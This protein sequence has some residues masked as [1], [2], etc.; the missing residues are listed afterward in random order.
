MPLKIDLHV[1]TCYS[2]DCATTLEEVVLFSKKKGLD[3]VAVT[4][5]DAI[6]GALR[7][8]EG[9][10][11]DLIVI[12]GIEVSTDRGHILG[13][14]VKTRIP[15]GLSIEETIRRIHEA[16]GIAVV[17]HPSAIL[18]NGVGLDEEIASHDLDAVE[19]IN[20]A[21]FPFFLLSYLNRRF[22]DRVSLPQTAGSDSHLPE[23]VGL[24]YTIV[25]NAGPEMAVEE[26]VQAIK[27]GM[28]V[29]FGMPEPWKLRIRRITEKRKEK[30]GLS[31][32]AGKDRNRR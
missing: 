20:S 14:N 17:A 5:H 4:D 26:V 13:I 2:D 15:A 21:D 18:R 27:E 11:T 16:G 6:E 9:E 1:H 8:L 29:P 10:D 22:A 28:T 19:V 23:A 32:R 12:P 24:A 3:G 7:L 25:E 30:R 31:S